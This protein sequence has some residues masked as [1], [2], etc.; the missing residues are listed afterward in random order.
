MRKYLIVAIFF[1]L[2]VK[3][4]SQG[5]YVVESSGVFGNTATYLKKINIVGTTV[6][7]QFISTC[8]LY[9]IASVAV[10]KNTLYYSSYNSLT[11]STIA[12]VST[13]NCSY[14]AIPYNSGL[15]ADKNGVLYSANL[16]QLSKTDPNNGYATTL[17]GNMPYNCGG[18]LLFYKNEL[19]MASG[20]GIVKIDLTNL[21]NSSVV[22][23]GMYNVYGLA[24]ITSSGNQT[25][26]YAL[27]YNYINN[28]TDIYELDLVKGQSGPVIATLPY[29]VLDAGNALPNEISVNQQADCPFTGNGTIQLVF[30]TPVT[31]YQ[32]TLNGITNNTG[33][34]TN[35]AAGTYQISVNSGIDV[36]TI[37][38]TVPDYN[39]NKPVL[40]YVSTNPVCDTPGSIKLTITGADT[41]LYK[42]KYGNTTFASGLSVTG[43]APGNY[44]FDVINAAGCAVTSTDVILNRSKCQIVLDSVS[45][46]QECNRINKATVQVITQPT[47]YNPHN[48][49][50]L[51]SLTDTTGVF[52][53]LSP[54]NYSIT[55]ASSED[56]KHVNITIPN[57]KLNG[58]TV[59]FTT[60]KATCDTKGA[61]KFSMLVTSDQYQI[62]FN[63]DI[64]PFNYD[65][66][67]MDAGSYDFTVLK[68]DG[69]LLDSYTVNVETTCDGLLFPNTFTPNGDGINDVFRP[70]GNFKADNYKLQ[71][72]NRYGAVVFVS[73]NS[74]IGWNGQYNGNKATL[75]E[76]YWLASYV[77]N[78]GKIIKK[79]G[80][81][82]LLR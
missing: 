32:Y 76:Y 40:N 69:C 49:Y 28:T 13:T 56:Q 67:N 14:H 34:F 6:T 64:Y 33:L 31:N 75:G 54:G 5:F 55:I 9:G 36:S 77:S 27:S 17:V 30:D 80:H 4:F 48:V 79:S 41:S 8:N 23:P 63:N 47:H 10:Y 42:I 22:I 38:V 18:D 29:I 16:N 1:L 43:L 60:Q 3:V 37:S 78:N 21:T 25:K 46:Q 44:H 73:E 24:S 45:I 19:Y 15:T 51:N 74:G 65:F 35:V 71:I 57:Y 53:N 11:A 12:G 20:D 58:P 70:L 72:Y 61:I 82:T 59:T 68:P 26:V 2:S 7:E 66:N 81:I 50:T 52:N 62:K 39:A